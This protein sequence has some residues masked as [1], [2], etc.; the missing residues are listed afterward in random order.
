MNI[1]LSFT[2]MVWFFMSLRQSSS[3]QQN[4][5]SGEGGCSHIKTY[6][7]MWGSNGSPL[8]HK[9]SLNMGWSPIFY[10]NW[11]LFPKFPKFLGIRMANTRKL[12]K[13]GLYF[14]KNPLTKWFL[15]QSKWLLNMGKGFEARVAVSRPNQSLRG[16][17]PAAGP[18]ARQLCCHGPQKFL[19]PRKLSQTE[20]W[21]I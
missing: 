9:K 16:L 4:W 13:I 5:L 8:F 19:V 12:W 6:T 2:C 21:T 10:K 3:H 15:F 14:E 11:F 7:G 20:T 1:I 18:A 17:S